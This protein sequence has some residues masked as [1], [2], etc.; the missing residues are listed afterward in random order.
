VT[1]LPPGGANGELAVGRDKVADGLNQH[2]EH[3]SS[4]VDPQS[5]VVA[6]HRNQRG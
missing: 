2:F 6:S 1:L 3:R 5:G 4:T